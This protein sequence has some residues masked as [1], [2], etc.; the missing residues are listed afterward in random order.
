VIA[1]ARSTVKVH[2]FVASLKPD[3]QSRIKVA[4]LDVTDGEDEIK[5]KVDAMALLW[6]GIDV[7]VNNAGAPIT[8]PASRR[9]FLSHFMTIRF[10]LAR[11]G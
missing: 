4:Q 2:E 7:L 5:N 3:A 6:G 1:T 10:W 8:G 9:V 11:F